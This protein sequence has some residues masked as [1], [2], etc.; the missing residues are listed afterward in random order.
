VFVIT[1]TLAAGAISWINVESAN[2]HIIAKKLIQDQVESSSDRFEN[3]TK[4][5]SDRFQKVA[6]A[7]ERMEKLMNKLVV[8]QT[9]SKINQ[10]R[11]LKKLEL[12]YEEIDSF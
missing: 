1:V 2:R 5:N 8:S 3:A 9:E 11:I 7:F 12:E 6:E 4:Q 10:K